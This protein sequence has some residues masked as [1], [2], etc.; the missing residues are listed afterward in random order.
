M[1]KK[2]QKTISNRQKAYEKARTFCA[3]QERTQEEVRQRLSQWGWYGDEAEEII[4]ELISENFINEERFAKIYAGGKFR[5]KKWGRMK[6]K[7]AL[8]NK[9]LSTYCIQQAMKEINDEDYE[10]TL[11][12]LIEKKQ[13]ALQKIAPEESEAIKNL[14]IAQYLISK[15]YENDWIWLCLKKWKET[16]L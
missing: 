6:I 1:I 2:P 9:N 7:Q 16:Q 12:A 3:Y 5:I 8:K 14:K 15:G 10:N 11:M 13:E 4:V